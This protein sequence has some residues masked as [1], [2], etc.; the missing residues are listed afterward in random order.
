[1]L[2]PKTD[3]VNLGGG[4]GGGRVTHTH[5][6]TQTPCGT[7]VNHNLVKL[8][9]ASRE[10]GRIIYGEEE[11]CVKPIALYHITG[12]GWDPLAVTIT[13]LSVSVCMFNCL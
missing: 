5:T 1:M 9:Q 6:H 4:G 11:W 8:A 10:L 2:K 12:Q 7:A 13:C 3:P